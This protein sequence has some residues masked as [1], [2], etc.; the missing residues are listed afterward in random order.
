MAEPQVLYAQNIHFAATAAG[1]LGPTTLLDG[2]TECSVSTSIDSI[3]ANYFGSD[4]YKKNVTT[5]RGISINVSGHRHRG[6]AAQD[7]MESLVATGAVGYLTI[8]RDAA[9]EE[10]EQGLRYAVRVMSFDSGGPSSDVDKLTVSLTGQGAPV[11]V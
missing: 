9:A 2:V 3:D 11:P 7:L 5:L 8:I 4:G 10:G 1:V 6:N